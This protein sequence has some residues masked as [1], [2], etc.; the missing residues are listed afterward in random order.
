MQQLLTNV[1]W[2]CLHAN[3]TLSTIYVERLDRIISKVL[4][5]TKFALLNIC[6]VGLY[7]NVTA[8]SIVGRLVENK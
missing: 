4:C 1:L 5:E 3:W 7:V 6:A 8:L 2:I